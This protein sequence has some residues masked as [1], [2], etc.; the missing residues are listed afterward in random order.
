MSEEDDELE[1]DYEDDF[2]EGWEEDLDEDDSEQLTDGFPYSLQAKDFL[3][4]R[5]IAWR[6]FCG[7]VLRY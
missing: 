6:S 3:N 1:E 5:L 7:W 4:A 2:D